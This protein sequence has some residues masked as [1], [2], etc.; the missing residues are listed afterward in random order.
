[1]AFISLHVSLLP[2]SRLFLYRNFE[3]RNLC[4]SN[5]GV[6]TCCIKIRYCPI[7]ILVNTCT[8]A[9][10]IDTYDWSYLSCISEHHVYKEIW[11]LFIGEE[12]KCMCETNDVSIVALWL[13]VWCPCSP[14][15]F[16]VGCLYC[17]G[18]HAS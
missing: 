15:N 11:Q 12:L 2:Y 14:T 18:R 7:K 1:M 17:C 8:M 5:F 9:V 4:G 16:S 10:S 3:F 6:C 13:P